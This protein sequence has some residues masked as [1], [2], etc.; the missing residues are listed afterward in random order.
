MVM[1][2]ATATATARAR[3]GSWPEF[4]NEMDEVD[5]LA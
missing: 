5:G 1:V 3:A 4:I 2:M